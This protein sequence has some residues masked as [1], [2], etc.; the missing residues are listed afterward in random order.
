MLREPGTDANR[1]WCILDRWN[2]IGN[3]QCGVNLN[4][5]TQRVTLDG[6]DLEASQS[7]DAYWWF[8][9]VKC[10]TLEDYIA[11]GY[12]ALY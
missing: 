11:N 8:Q 12:Q 9:K 2:I 10:T 1:N 6:Q 3:Y 7:G 5:Q 4:E